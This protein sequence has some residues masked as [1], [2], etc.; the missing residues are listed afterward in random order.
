MITCDNIAEAIEKKVITLPDKLIGTFVNYN[1]GQKNSVVEFVYFPREN[2]NAIDLALR[3]PDMRSMEVQTL[4]SKR[5]L[6]IKKNHDTRVF[7]FPISAILHQIT[8]KERNPKYISY[9]ESLSKA[10]LLP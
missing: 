7:A 3:G 6:F 9:K 8:I 1:L 2:Y 10:R 5:I 4:D